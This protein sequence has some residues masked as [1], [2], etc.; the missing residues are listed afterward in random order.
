M[1]LFFNIGEGGD[2]YSYAEFVAAGEFGEEDDITLCFGEGSHCFETSWNHP[3]TTLRLKGAELCSRDKQRSCECDKN[4]STEL[5]I[6][7]FGGLQGFGF[8]HKGRKYGSIVARTNSHQGV[9]YTGHGEYEFTYNK[10]CDGC[11]NSIKVCSEI[12]PNFNALTQRLSNVEYV[13]AMFYHAP[14]GKMKDFEIVG[15]DK[16]TIYVRGFPNVECPSK[17]D[18]FTIL[19]VSVLNVGDTEVVNLIAKNVT[20][21]GL[22]IVGKGQIQYQTDYVDWRYTVHIGVKHFLWGG[23]SRSPRHDTHFYSK[24]NMAC[25]AAH[26]SYN[27]TYCGS[28]SGEL[29]SGGSS[30][31]MGGDFIGCNVGVDSDSG[32]ITN[33]YMCEF[34]N[35][36][37]G[38]TSFN[39]AV[40]NTKKTE[41]DN[42]VVGITA[43]QGGSICSKRDAM[44]ETIGEGTLKFIDC[45]LAIRINESSIDRHDA[46]EF[47]SNLVDLEFDTVVYPVI[48]G[49][50]SGTE[51]VNESKLFYT[52]A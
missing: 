42:C 13:T 27:A 12:G 24:T 15:V 17:G 11:V 21:E 49:Y 35:C 4:T 16:N 31:I 26:V 30:L 18:T 33:L 6:S 40:V 19:P 10:D 52:L 44:D 46:L 8:V 37:N 22:R 28:C 9:T 43:I 32:N 48:T 14:T 25:Q 45:D 38:V 5:N 51:G 47:D 41:F 1:K 3:E 2:Y 7:T 29:C 34:I 23:T 50:V 20:Y 36:V 39:N